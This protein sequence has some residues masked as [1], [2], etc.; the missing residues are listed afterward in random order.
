M[1]LAFAR[2][3]TLTKRELLMYLASPIPYVFIV[4]FLVLA[5]VMTFVM[6]RFFER[7]EAD[8]GPSFFVWLPWLF[9]G[10]VPA[11]GMRLWSDEMRTGTMELLMTYPM[12]AWHAVVAKF[13]AATAVV[14][15]AVLG[16]FPIVL[17]AAYLGSPDLGAVACGYL[18]A[19][20]MAAAYLAIAGVASAST[21]NQIVA[22]ILSVVAGL[23][24]I[25][26]G[27]GPV[28]GQLIERLPDARWLVDAAGALGMTTHYD[29]FT[30]G[31][32]RLSGVFYFGSIV[33]ASLYLTVLM[34]EGRR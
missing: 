13:L 17:T 27:F 34:L 16:T 3:R 31:V 29:G 22:L 33:L 11:V 28:T 20:L 21:P 5:A 10:L 25:L 1:R 9:L 15:A 6:G 12:R 8:L 23:A 7:G 19:L 30:R 32:V 26:V 4:M 2:I 14:W 18:G 24:L